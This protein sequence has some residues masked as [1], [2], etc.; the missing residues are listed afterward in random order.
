SGFAGDGVDASDIIFTA[1]SVYVYLGGEA[2]ADRANLILTL[3]SPNEVPVITPNGGGPTATINIDEN[4]TAVTTVTATDA[5]T[6]D[7]KFFS[8]SG[9]ED[10]ALFHI[11]SDTGVL[12]L[13]SPLDFENLPPAGATPGYQVLVQ[14][15]DGYGGTD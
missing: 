12:T 9:G 7:A 11:D 15:A 1:D 5:D 2:R 14:V 8:I 4:P 10:S 3:T 13:N 6:V